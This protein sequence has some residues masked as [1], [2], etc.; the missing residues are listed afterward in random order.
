MKKRGELGRAGTEA[1][2]VKRV[3]AAG[4]VSRKLVWPGV[5]G[6]PDRLDLYGIE[7]AA[8]RFSALVGCSISD[9]TICRG[10]AQSI[11]ADAIQFTETKATG[12]KPRGDQLR[13]HKELRAMGFIVNVVDR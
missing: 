5:N 12:K 7:H 3:K 6:A 13:R 4:G 8:K 2:H 11:I 1:L 9:C 10:Q